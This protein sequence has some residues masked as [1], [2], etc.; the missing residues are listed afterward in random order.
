MGQVCDE[1][2]TSGINILNY[3]FMGKQSFSG[4][5]MFAQNDI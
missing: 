2:V 5:N 4:A 3:V 1:I